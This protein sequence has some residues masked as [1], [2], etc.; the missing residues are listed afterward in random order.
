MLQLSNGAQ[1]RLKIGPKEKRER[2]ARKHVGQECSPSCRSTLPET[3]ACRHARTGWTTAHRDTSPS[4]ANGPNYMYIHTYITFTCVCIERSGVS[5]MLLNNWH[6]VVEYLLHV[7]FQGTIANKTSDGFMF[8]KKPRKSRKKARS[9]KNP[10]PTDKKRMRA[11]EEW[12][13]LS[14]GKVSSDTTNYW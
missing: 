4:E 9:T 1:G 3:A 8:E 14:N 13:S 5:K 7:L 12:K 2:E 11:G 6:W 10:R